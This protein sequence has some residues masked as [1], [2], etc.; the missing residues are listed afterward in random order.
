[1]SGGRNLTSSWALSAQWHNAAMNKHVVLIIHVQTT[2][3]MHT[4]LLR[5][6]VHKPVESALALLAR[7]GRGSNVACAIRVQLLR[8]TSQQRNGTHA[9]TPISRTPVL[10]P[11]K[12][13]R[14]AKTCC[15]QSTALARPGHRTLFTM[16]RSVRSAAASA[17]L[18]WWASNNFV[19]RYARSP[20]SGDTLI[21]MSKICATTGPSCAY[22]DD[23][24]QCHK[25][26]CAAKLCM[27]RTS[28]GVFVSS[29]SATACATSKTSRWA[30]VKVR[31]ADA[32]AANTSFMSLRAL[33]V[34]LCSPA[35]E[36]TRS[37]ERYTGHSSA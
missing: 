22:A 32:T 15:L 13:P 28:I 23:A 34:Y 11:R 7:G 36:D 6:A 14:P 5:S 35:W 25:H 8:H 10:P 20:M 37:H 9:A 24:Q 17:W 16:L 27:A 31:C 18:Y 3:Y 2:T 21:P 12:L 29:T 33:P 26:A 4:Y 30:A 1:M 19:A